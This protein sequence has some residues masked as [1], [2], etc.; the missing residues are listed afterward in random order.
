MSPLRT[1]TYMSNMVYPSLFLLVF[2]S[3]APAALAQLPP[4][5]AQLNELVS[6]GQYQRAWEIANANVEMWEGDTQFDLL[7]GIAAL[8]SGRPNEAVYALQ[9]AVA[10][11]QTSLVRGA[12]PSKLAPGKGL[13]AKKCGEMTVS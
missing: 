11:A 6:S 4:P 12:G 7:Y 9:R 2:S 10:T 3:L 5:N 13:G 8:E 1:A